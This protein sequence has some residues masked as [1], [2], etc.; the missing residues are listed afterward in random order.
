M[1]PNDKDIALSLLIYLTAMVCGLAVVVVPIYLAN[2]PLVIA[3]ADAGGREGPAIFPL[4]SS[5]RVFPV[6]QLKDE[7][8]VPAAEVAESNAAA[9]AAERA[10]AAPVHLA[11]GGQAPR[12]ASSHRS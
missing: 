4:R 10:H 11:R 6:A 3:N 5:Q 1:S 7:T 8:I 2:Q 9:K 12:R